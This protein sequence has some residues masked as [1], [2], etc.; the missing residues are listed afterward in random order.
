MMRV[1]ATFQIARQDWQAME[2]QDFTQDVWDAFW[3][4][5][6]AS[7]VPGS[8]L[9]KGGVTL[10]DRW[11]LLEAMWSL[12]DLDEAEGKAA[13]LETRMTRRLTRMAEREARQKLSQSQT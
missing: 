1:S 9:P 4:L 3:Q 13:A 8:K 12:N 10:A 6:N 7:L 5:V 2:K 11:A